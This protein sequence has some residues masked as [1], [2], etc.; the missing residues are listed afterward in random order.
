MSDPTARFAIHPGL[1]KS[2]SDG[3]WHYIGVEKLVKLYNV[4]PGSYMVWDEDRP[5][6]FRGR[7]PL[8]YKHLYPRMEG[9][10]WNVQ[11]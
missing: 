1:E 2:T 8:G 7:N 5:E 10:Y 6:T 9:D 3:D 11:Q 4:P